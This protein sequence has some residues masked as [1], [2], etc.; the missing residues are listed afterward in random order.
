MREA[1]T[2]LEREGLLVSSSHRGVVVFCPSIDDLHQI[3]EIRIP[4]E[5]LAAEKAAELI[6]DD[7]LAQIGELLAEMARS[8]A[9]MDR[10]PELNRR[11][12]RASTRSPSGRS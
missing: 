12:I 6:T 10:Y 3:Y 2:A 11:F 1:F 9:D 5:A 8:T 4:L 7:D